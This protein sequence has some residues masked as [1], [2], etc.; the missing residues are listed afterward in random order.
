MDSTLKNIIFDMGGVLVDLC[1]ERSIAAFE[2]LGASEVALY[3]REFR[4]EDLFLQLELGSISTAQ[5]CDEARR[6]AHISAPDEAIISAWDTLLEPSTDIRRESLLRLKR[7]GYR[8]FV[9]S[10]T[11]D[12]HWQSASR[13]LIPAPGLSINDYF[14]RCFLSYEMHCRKPSPEIYLR[15]LEEAHLT[16]GETLFIDDNETNLLSAASLGIHVFLEHS[17]HRWTDLLIPSLL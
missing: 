13:R 8:L 1:P 4:M 14:E 10:N 7:A 6:I 9:L 16:A 2:A 3:I 11:C 5:F 17:S 15:A 12:I